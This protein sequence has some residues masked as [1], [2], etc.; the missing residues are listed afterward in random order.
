M[1]AWRWQETEAEDHMSVWGWL[2][3]VSE[4][5]VS[6]YKVLHCRHW[7]ARSRAMEATVFVASY[8]ISWWRC[9][10][11][12][13]RPS[14]RRRWWTFMRLETHWSKCSRGWTRCKWWAQNRQVVTTRS[15]SMRQ[16]RCLWIRPAKARR[17]GIPPDSERRIVSPDGCT[18]SRMPLDSRTKRTRKRASKYM[19]TAFEESHTNS[20]DGT[21]V[22]TD[23]EVVTLQEVIRSWMT[24]FVSR[25]WD[26]IEN[27]VSADF[28]SSDPWKVEQK[29]PTNASCHHALKCYVARFIV[30]KAS[31]EMRLKETFNCICKG[32]AGTMWRDAGFVLTRLFEVCWHS[33]VFNSSHLRLLEYCSMETVC[34]ELKGVRRQCRSLSFPWEKQKLSWIRKRRTEDWEMIQCA[35]VDLPSHL[36]REEEWTFH[37]CQSVFGVCWSA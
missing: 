19:V 14:S 35:W 33:H 10:R 4:G 32:A 8:E 28:K 20:I 3:N 5:Y 30:R 23:P 1:S 13:R 31:V 25:S 22:A 34:S 9:R 11:S 15:G 7:L 2:E 36:M 21:M 24:E 16:I 37:R 12:S 17:R 29:A 27:G 18:K 26:V 6:E